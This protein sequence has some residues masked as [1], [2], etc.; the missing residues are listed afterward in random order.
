MSLFTAQPTVD[1]P[2]AENA[3]PP[4][5][6]IP[7]FEEC[8]ATV[9]EWGVWPAEFFVAD[10]AHD[11][12]ATCAASAT[13][14]ESRVRCG[15]TPVNRNC[16]AL[17]PDS[18]CVFKWAQ[19]TT[20]TA[21][22]C[23]CQCCLLGA[24]QCEM[25]SAVIVPLPP[26]QTECQFQSGL[27]P[28][29]AP[30][31]IYSETNSTSSMIMDTARPRMLPPCSILSN[32]PTSLSKEDCLFNPHHHHQYSTSPINQPFYDNA[33]PSLFHSEHSE[34][35]PAG[36][37][38]SP[39]S[40]ASTSPFPTFEDSE[41]PFLDSLIA[42]VRQEMSVDEGEVTVPSP[43]TS[44]DISSV[45][46]KSS[47][48]TSSSLRDVFVQPGQTLVIRGDDGQ[49]YKVIVERVEESAPVSIK[50]K[51]S[52]DSLIAPKRAR[53]APVSLVNLSDEEIAERKKQQNRAAALRY[54]QK[55]RESRVLSV[56]AKETLSQRN[57]Y[58]RD[59]AERL[60]KEC[61]VL[62]RLIFDKLG[63]N[64]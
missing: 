45:S 48:S 40:A 39:N 42:Q 57:A 60:T 6:F 50:R 38:Y 52:D 34:Y 32:S 54:R 19:A 43:S 49:E 18:K 46:R 15:N 33:S 62:R 41:I 61:D 13:E 21:T 11:Q 56:S 25:V 26:C 59:E 27:V 63:K 14:I 23:S 5:P 30:G 3:P 55:L 24:D 10:P 37:V 58:L 9:N 28:S 17:V 1:M 36:V 53:A 12:T 2:S 20:A 44:S 8:N 31:P 35:S 22:L 47:S 4:P 7:P 16:T 64:V 29:T 51:S